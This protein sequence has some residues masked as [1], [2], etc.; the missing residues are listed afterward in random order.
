MEWVFAHM[1]EEGFDAPLTAPEPAAG[2]AGGGAGGAGGG[3]DPSAE[4]VEMLCAMGFGPAHAAAA[5]RHTAGSLERA[6]DWLFSHADDLDA[7]VAALVGAKAGAGAGGGG[8]GGG[9]GAA[10]EPLD[11]GVG[12]SRARLAVRRTPAVPPRR[13]PALTRPPASC[14]R[15]P[16]RARQHRSPLCP[17]AAA[18]RVRAGGLRVAHGRQPGLRALRRAREGQGR[19]RLGALGAL[20]RPQGAKAREEAREAGGEGGCWARRG[21]AGMEVARLLHRAQL[22]GWLRAAGCCLSARRAPPWPSL[23]LSESLPHQNPLLPSGL[24]RA[25]PSVRAR[26]RRP[27]VAV[28]EAPPL[29][30]GY[31]YLYRRTTPSTPPPQ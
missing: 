22:R 18:R 1:H 25:A 13:V 31:M 10:S 23:A 14:P 19:R 6:A 30:L 20:Q 26:A 11:D 16:S 17:S 9:G 24:F 15:L 7:A 12:A 2:G 27:Q 4:S 21:S 28:S 8:A 3:D 5:L 29:D